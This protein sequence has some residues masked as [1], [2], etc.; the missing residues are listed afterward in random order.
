MRITVVNSSLIVLYM[1]NGIHYLPWG[2]SGSP[3]PE[4]ATGLAKVA[5]TMA[6][7]FRLQ[8][9]SLDDQEDKGTLEDAELAADKLVQLGVAYKNP[10][11]RHIIFH[12]LLQEYARARED[13]MTA[14]AATL[15]AVHGKHPHGPWLVCLRR[16][17]RYTLGR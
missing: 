11:T 3:P 10:E 17:L 12:P 5:E 4:A 15:Q 16:R 6:G 9:L 13:H 7:A 1:H 8:A 14:V 2:R